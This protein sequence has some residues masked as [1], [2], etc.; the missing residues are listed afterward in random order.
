MSGLVRELGGFR[1]CWTIVFGV[2][3]SGFRFSF[4]VWA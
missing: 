2:L 4:R 3:V 1:V